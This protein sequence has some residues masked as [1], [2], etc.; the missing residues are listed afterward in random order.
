MRKQFLLFVTLFV[1][2]VSLAQE[3][4]A[5]D[6]KIK[7]DKATVFEVEKKKQGFMKEAKFDLMTADGKTVASA[8]QR[9]FH[10]QLYGQSVN[11]FH[12]EFPSFNDSL[13]L[14]HKQ[15]SEY[16]S[17]GMLGMKDDA[18]AKF[19]VKV[20]LV[21]SDGTLN[22]E[23][24]A[25]LKAQYADDISAKTAKQQAEETACLKSITELTPR[26]KKN[27]LEVKEIKRE[28]PQPG[29]LSV[30][31]YEIT[32]GGVVIGTVTAAGHPS[33]LND[34]KAEI[35]FEG[36]IMSLDNEASPFT[37]EFKTASGCLF[38][39]YNP[40]EKTLF[41]WKDRQPKTLKTM[42]GKKINDMKMR[43]ELINEMAV[44]LEKNLFL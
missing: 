34:E 12:F 13:Q 3:F 29:K 6:N 16:V 18:Y 40:T 44:Y 33:K 42:V 28:E 10:P 35:D 9:F 37:Y 17:V 43:I 4:K 15:L 1:S 8:Q 38:A 5:D 14:S 23:K 25:A 2:I 7:L 20:G 32:Q 41:T 21:N 24:F 11:W 19:Y 22:A 26:D 36:G 31:T 30:I 27:A 39:R